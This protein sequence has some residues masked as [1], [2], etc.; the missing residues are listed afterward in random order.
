[1]AYTLEQLLRL[2]WTY[3]GPRQTG[4]GEDSCWELRIA[5][6][7]GFLVAG[8]TRDEVLVELF[9]ALRTFL[10]SYLEH[11]EVPPLPADPDLWRMVLYRA[12]REPALRPA[13]GAPWEATQGANPEAVFASG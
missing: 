7:P 4:E 13:F 2:P 12:K 3:Q 10:E 5:E 1:M 8:F 6:L 9:P 11:N